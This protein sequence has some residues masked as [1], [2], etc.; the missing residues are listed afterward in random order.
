MQYV[1][2]PRLAR[3]LPQGQKRDRLNQ[4]QDRCNQPQGPVSLVLDLRPVR[5]NQRQ[6]LLLGLRLVRLNQRQGRR[7]GRLSQR[8]G[9]LLGLRLVR[10]NQRQGPLLGLRPARLSLRQGPLLVR[11]SQRQDRLPDPRR[12]PNSSVN[13]RR[14]RM[15]RNLSAEPNYIKKGRTRDAFS[16]SLFA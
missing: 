1:P 15:K 11:L 9:P 4:P 8:Q 3:S 14:R 13:S 16:P 10:L 12:V 2:Q 5:L 6:G 7:L